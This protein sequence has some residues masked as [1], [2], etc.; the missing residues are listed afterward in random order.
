MGSFLAFRA[1]IFD[2]MVQDVE[3][4]PANCISFF[5]FFPFLVFRLYPLVPYSVEICFRDNGDTGQGK[6]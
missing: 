3:T 2:A 1:L 4:M 6:A 5:L